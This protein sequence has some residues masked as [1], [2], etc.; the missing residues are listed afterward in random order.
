MP[1]IGYILLAVAL[2]GGVGYF[3]YR[4]TREENEKSKPSPTPTPDPNPDPNPPVDDPSED[5][6]DLPENPIDD[7]V[8]D[9]IDLPVGPPGGPSE[10]YPREA[11]VNLDSV[12]LQKVKGI[13]DATEKT[14]KDHYSSLSEINEAS[15]EE[16]LSL[17]RVTDD[18]KDRLRDF[19]SSD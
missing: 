11:E 9:P 4:K 12:D 19:V 10:E 16:L 15:E 17:P 1:T 6:V 14:I 13:G 18:I 2:L 5:P 7:P 3:I 8:D